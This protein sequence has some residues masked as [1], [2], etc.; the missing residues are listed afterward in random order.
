MIDF[1]P[2]N[3]IGFDLDNTLFDQSLYEFSIFQKI[4][5]AIE[6]HYDLE[7]KSYYKALKLL[8]RSGEKAHTFDKALLKCLP[9]L[10][11]NWEETMS[12]MVLPVY[13]K[14]FPKTLTPFTFSLPLLSALKKEKKWYSLLM[15]GKKHRM[16]KL[17]LW[18]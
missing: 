18:G 8:Y 2:Y 12:N 7:P 6:S 10:P 14:H 11:S 5:L 1:Q 16:Q 4:A 13:R 17:M 15:G 9:I 3:I